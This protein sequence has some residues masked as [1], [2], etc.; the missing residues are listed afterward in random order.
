MAR[1]C[2]VT[3]ILFPQ[4]K[5][6]QSAPL[7]ILPL[8]A[9]V[10]STQLKDTCSTVLYCIST[11]P[12]AAWAVCAVFYTGIMSF[13]FF[14]RSHRNAM[15]KFPSFSFHDSPS[16]LLFF[17][18]FLSFNWVQAKMDVF[19]PRSLSW[20]GTYSQVRSALLKPQA[21]FG[22]WAHWEMTP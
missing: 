1:L 14:H 12:V 10:K 6:S 9:K 11:F 8:R 22:A 21:R 5:I 20:N 16:F 3:S 15:L 18:P 19:V 7:L 4:L 13:S 17:L 2:I